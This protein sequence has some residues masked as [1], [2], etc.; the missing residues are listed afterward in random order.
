MNVFEYNTYMH[1]L[2]YVISYSGNMMTFFKNMMIIPRLQSI[3][4][5]FKISKVKS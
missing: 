3:I 4:S 5:A 1:K 2:Y